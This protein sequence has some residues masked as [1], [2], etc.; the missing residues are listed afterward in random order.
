MAMLYMSAAT[1]H[2]H[3]LTT[4]ADIPSAYRTLTPLLGPAAGFVFAISLLA[5]GLSSSTVGTMAGQVIMQGFVGFTIPVWVRRLATMAPTVV[6]V[7]LGIDPTH[8]LVISQVVL[9]MVLPI[10]VIALT[11]LTRRRDLMGSLVN[12]RTTTVLATLCATVILVL[13]MVLLY[14][15]GGGALPG[16]S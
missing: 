7:W 8:A 4:V 13:N 1:F 12:R 16:L 11:L 14:Q 2:G 3:G 15:T 9:S 6:I 5:S 10:P